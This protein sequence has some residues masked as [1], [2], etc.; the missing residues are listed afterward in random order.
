MKLAALSRWRAWLWRAALFFSG[1]GLALGAFF[2]R[3]ETPGR[4]LSNFGASVAFVSPIVGIS[5]ITST[6]GERRQARGKTSV[7]E[8]EVISTEEAS[9]VRL[10]FPNGARVL[11]RGK[12]QVLVNR[13]WQESFWR[14]EL[15]V[16][17]GSV[18]VEIKGEPALSILE[19]KREISWPEQLLLS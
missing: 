11:L 19:E 10:T 1:L 4:G 5:F 2:F 14:E 8:N 16:L 6:S 9:Q 15:K 17:S 13:Y 12:T 3:L 7:F 18:Q